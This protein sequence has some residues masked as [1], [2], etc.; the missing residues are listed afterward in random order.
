MISLTQL[1][2]PSLPTVLVGTLVTF[3]VV[4]S[5]YRLLW[6]PL[7]SFPGPKLAAVTKWYEFYF[8][9]VKGHG[10]QFA[11]EIQRMHKKYGESLPVPSS[12]IIGNVL[13]H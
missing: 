10:G 2:L 3:L 6:H 13:T 4:Q 1:L 9:I 5:I 7:A 12:N 11:W 8:D